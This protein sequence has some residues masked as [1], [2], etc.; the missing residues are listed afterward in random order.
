MATVPEGTNAHSITQKVSVEAKG[1]IKVRAK[2]EVKGRKEDQ[3][4]E[5]TRN[6]RKALEVLGPARSLESV[7][8][9]VE[10]PLPTLEARSAEIMW[11]ASVPE[12]RTASGLALLFANIT[13]MDTAKRGRAANTCTLSAVKPPGS[14]QKTEGGPWKRLLK[15]TDYL[16]Q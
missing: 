15:E 6:H 13:K 2:A 10:A 11:L 16:E 8:G 7:L 14:P 9:L 3:D 5:A 4:P 12:A 1:K